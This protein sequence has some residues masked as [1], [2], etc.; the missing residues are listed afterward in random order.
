MH[1]T[2]SLASSEST[3]GA[4]LT[5][6]APKLTHHACRHMEKQIKV[7]IYQLWTFRVYYICFLAS[8]HSGIFSV[9]LLF[10][11]VCLKFKAGYSWSNLISDHTTTCETPLLWNSSQS[12]S[13]RVS[14]CGGSWLLLCSLKE[15]VKSTGGKSSLQKSCGGWELR[16]SQK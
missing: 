14:V 15:A 2:H 4:S 6:L 3:K 10:M 11:C 16:R 1:E 13:H 8:R 5:F 7:F 9:V 12:R